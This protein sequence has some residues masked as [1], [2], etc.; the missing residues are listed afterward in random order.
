VLSEIMKATGAKEFVA[1]EAD[2]LDGI[3]WSLARN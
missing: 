1:S 2:I 3:A